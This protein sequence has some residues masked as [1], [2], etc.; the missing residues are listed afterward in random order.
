VIIAFLLVPWV[1][2]V[3]MAA[4]FMMVYAFG[5]G[6]IDMT[7]PFVVSAKDIVQGSILKAYEATIFIGGPLYLLF[8]RM[9]WTNL[10]TSMVAGGVIALVALTVSVDEFGRVSWDGLP[11]PLRDSGAPIM[12]FV[13][14]GVTTGLTFWLAA[15]APLKSK[16][17]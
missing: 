3:T 14:A 2:P 17:V 6:P 1:G 10:A 11:G 15:F 16:A 12:V 8:R 9:K 4:I 13:I 5:G 7:G